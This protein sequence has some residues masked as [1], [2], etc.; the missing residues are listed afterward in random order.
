MDGDKGGER[1]WIDDEKIAPS[2][3]PACDAH[4]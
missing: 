3:D 4:H 2:P 1:L